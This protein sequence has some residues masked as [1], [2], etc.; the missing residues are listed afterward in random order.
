MYGVYRVYCGPL[1]K[2]VTFRVKSFEGPVVDWGTCFAGKLRLS[3]VST[4]RLAYLGMTVP[5]LL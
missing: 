5:T 4:Y 1:L 2:R 3:L